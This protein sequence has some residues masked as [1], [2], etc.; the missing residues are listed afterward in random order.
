[1]K[2]EKEGKGRQEVKASETMSPY[3]SS[4][5]RDSGTKATTFHYHKTLHQY[6]ITQHFYCCYI[7]TLKRLI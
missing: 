2:G 3:V 1:M 4:K 7:I 6:Y 5:K